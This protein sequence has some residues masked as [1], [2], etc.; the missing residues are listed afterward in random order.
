ML[1]INRWQNFTGQKAINEK[2]QKTY[3]EMKNGE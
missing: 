2:E 3:E 1:I